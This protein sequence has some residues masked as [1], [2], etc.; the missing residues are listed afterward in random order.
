MSWE[1]LQVLLL[2]DEKESLYLSK[3]AI[4]NFVPEE[5]IQCAYTIEEAMEILKKGVIDIAFLDVEL[6]HSSGFALSEYIQRNHSE[7]EIVILTGHVDFAAQGYDYDPLD[8]LIKPVDILRMEKTFLRYSEKKKQAKQLPRIMVET[9]S[10]FALIDPDEIKYITKD[11][12]SVEIRCRDGSTIKVNYSLD[13][14]EKKF[15]QFGFFRT[16]QSYLV[17]ISRIIRV[18]AAS[19]GNSFDA[20]LDDGTKLPVSRGKFAKLKKYLNIQSLKSI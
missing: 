1:T 15:S 4:S 3:Q 7:V 9:G 17:P 11:R 14:M 19:Y 2:D 20:V 6:T 16:H 8:F 18:R 10:G 12:H 5:Q 13:Y